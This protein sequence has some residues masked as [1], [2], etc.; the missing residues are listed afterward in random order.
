MS[1]IIETLKDAADAAAAGLARST[2]VNE[3]FEIMF[4]YGA[5]D[6]RD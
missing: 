2:G 6:F 3:I 5:R 1:L 4:R